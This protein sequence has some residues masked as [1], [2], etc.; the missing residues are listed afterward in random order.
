MASIT[1]VWNSLLA[2]S[3]LGEVATWVDAVTT[4]FIILG[5]VVCVI[6]GASGSASQASQTIDDLVGTM[7]RP[8]VAIAASVLVVLYLIAFLYIRYTH[9]LGDKRTD[10]QKKAECEFA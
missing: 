10:Q 2:R 6:F 3:C 8:L 9:N 4:I 1:I 7:Q 5:A